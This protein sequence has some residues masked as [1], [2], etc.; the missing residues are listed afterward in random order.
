MRESVSHSE[1]D[2]QPYRYRW[3]LLAIVH[4][5]VTVLAG[6]MIVC[7]T[8]WASAGA[9]WGMFFGCV[10][11]RIE[12]PIARW[13]HDLVAPHWPVDA[14]AAIPDPYTEFLRHSS[15]PPSYPRRCWRRQ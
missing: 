15:L 3:A 11:C 14:P 8:V 4:A 5:P 12:A 1:F 7:M 2:D 6:V 10:L 9:F 13:L